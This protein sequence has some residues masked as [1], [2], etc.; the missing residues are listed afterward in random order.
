MLKPLHDYCLILPLKEASIS[1]KVIEIPERVNSDSREGIKRGKVIAVGPGLKHPKTGHR[2][3]MDVQAGDMVIYS[4][5][6]AFERYIDGERHDMVAERNI[7]AIT[8]EK[9][10]GAKPVNRVSMGFPILTKNKNTK[11][12]V[13]AR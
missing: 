1:S 3:E 7:I 2:L 13:Y 8:T 12:T 9:E 5:V 11:R 6:G 4:Q 10:A